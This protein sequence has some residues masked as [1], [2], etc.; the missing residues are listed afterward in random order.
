MA[1]EP[2]DPFNIVTYVFSLIEMFAIFIFTKQNIKYLKVFKDRIDP[3][4][5]TCFFFVLLTVLFKV[6]PKLLFTI[7]TTIFLDTVE[8]DPNSDFNMWYVEN[9][10]ELTCMQISSYIMSNI[11][12]TIALLINSTRWLLVLMVLE[13]ERN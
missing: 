8:K 4:T 9:S 2:Y 11:F 7:L 6:I 13:E 5:V 3:F 12:L 10:T 1:R